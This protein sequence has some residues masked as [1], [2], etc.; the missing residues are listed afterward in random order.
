MDNLLEVLAETLADGLSADPPAWTRN[1]PS[2]DKEWSL[3]ATPQ[4]MEHR[5]Q[6]TPPR[7]FER[8]L[9]VDRPSLWQNP[10]LV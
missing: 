7:F 1:I 2:R 3:P 8:G 4:M 6:D 9:L 5:R 10:P